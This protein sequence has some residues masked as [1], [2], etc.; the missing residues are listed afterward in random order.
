MG[1]MIDMLVNSIMDKT[2][3]KSNNKEEQPKEIT[4]TVIIKGIVMKI[5]DIEQNILDKYSEEIEKAQPKE[6]VKIIVRAVFDEIT[7][8]LTRKDT[9][10]IYK[11]GRFYPDF[12]QG[13]KGFN[14]AIGKE[15]VSK[16]KYAPKFEPS[17]V[18]KE[19][20]APVDVEN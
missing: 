10:Q 4:K 12:V 6:A 1:N 9:V 13:R 17:D 5:A 11:F 14:H 19:K 18:L 16:D 15:Y 8:A 20:V 7:E 2:I 3:N